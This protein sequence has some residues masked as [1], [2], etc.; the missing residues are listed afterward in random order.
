M[1]DAVTTLPAFKLAVG[2]AAIE[3]RAVAV[4]AFFVGVQHAVAAEGRRLRA[5]AFDTEN[6]GWTLHVGIA[7]VDNG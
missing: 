7:G 5:D 1:D 6:A 4:I 2:R 3:V